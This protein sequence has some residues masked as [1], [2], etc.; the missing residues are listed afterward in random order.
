VR[1]AAG[2]LAVAIASMLN[3]LNPSVVIIGGLSRLGELLL[4]PLRSAVRSRSLYWI[5]AS[6]RSSPARWGRGRWRWG[7]PPWRWRLRLRI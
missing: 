3:V 6:A 1:E 7:R 4:A 2:H 5:A